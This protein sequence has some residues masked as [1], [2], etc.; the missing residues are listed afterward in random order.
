[1]IVRA[2]LAWWALLVAR[3]A[4]QR[5]AG[6]QSRQ[7]RVTTLSSSA[8]DTNTFPTG[9]VANNTLWYFG[10]SQTAVDGVVSSPST[11]LWSSVTQSE[12]PAV[13]PHLTAI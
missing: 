3:P 10:G 7:Y 8:D 1:M 9:A 13:M 2:S 11:T 6:G 12:M 5:V 4:A